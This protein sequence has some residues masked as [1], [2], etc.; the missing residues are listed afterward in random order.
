MSLPYA[1]ATSGVRARGEILSILR[2]FGAESV[3]FMD[4][5]ETGTLL[6]A[7]KWRG[8]SVQL[9]ASAQGWASAFL[10]ENPWTAR[11]RYNRHDWEQRALEQG[12]KAV[13]S[14]LRDWVKGQVT[15]IETGILTFEHVFFSHMLT[16]DGTPLIDHARKLLPAPNENSHDTA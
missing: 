5:F 8:R 2:R 6:L 14:I 15:A 11:R 3:G 13:N 7:F 1:N 12:M 4:E 16:S 9:H 10:K